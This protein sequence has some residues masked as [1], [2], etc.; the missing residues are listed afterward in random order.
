MKL[1]YFYFIASL[2]L[3]ASCKNEAPLSDAYGNFEATTS[4]VSSEAK[5]QLLFLHVEEGQQLKAGQLIGLVDTTHLHLQRQQIRA[6]IQTLPKKLR[7]TIADIEVLENRKANM[8]RERDRVSRLLKKKAATSKQL[9]DINGEIDVV[10]KQIAAIRSTTQISNRAILAEKEPM[11]AQMAI[12]NNQIRK[13]YIYNTVDGTVLSKLAEPLEITNMGAPLYRIG[14]LDTMTLR[15]YAS[16][17]QLQD[18]KL[19]QKIEVLIDEGED[20]YQTLE[21]AVSWIS[22][23]AEFTPKTI[24]TKEERVHLVYAIKAKVPNP[25][26][27]LKMG[28]PAEVN[29]KPGTKAAQEE[30]MANKSK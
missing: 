23:Q 1:R 30:D 8:I 2:L 19:G 27:L 18:V 3:I 10:E 9:D 17:V 5:G 21:G 4:T 26:G 13:S 6:T 20:A 7:N 11:I 15:F 12:I 16:S 22:E 28:M 14:Q 25:N 24:Q 29:F